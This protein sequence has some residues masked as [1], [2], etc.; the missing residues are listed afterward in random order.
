[1]NFDSIEEFVLQ[2]FHSHLP[3]QNPVWDFMNTLH[4]V[5][6]KDILK[7]DDEELKNLSFRLKSRSK[8]ATCYY[9]CCF[10]VMDATP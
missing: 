3:P 5:Y 9:T 10:L 8:Q 6:V 1:M 7:V 4:P 2:T